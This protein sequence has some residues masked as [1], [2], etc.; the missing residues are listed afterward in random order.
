MLKILLASTNR[1]KLAEMHALL[2]D[3]EIRLLTP[4]DLNL[5]L[6]VVEDGATYRENAAKKAAAY[7]RAGGLLT[8]ADDSGL[9]VS[10]LGGQP[11]L[12]S[13]RF[14]PQPEAT[15]ADRRA[16]LLKR[17]QVHPRPWRAR[18][19]CAVALALPTG[20]PVFTEGICPGE[21]IPEERGASGFG[22]DPVFF[23]P[24]LGQ[25]MAELGMEEK[26]RISHRALAVKAAKPLILSL[27]D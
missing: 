26:N 17:L 19:I 25:T 16:Y 11:G 12:K 14:V 8:L 24:E 13:A 2:A 22:Y 1:G 21:I 18:F 9:E 27:L 15:D 7:A 6:D 4:S 10:A 5:Q 20:E 3:L 23:I